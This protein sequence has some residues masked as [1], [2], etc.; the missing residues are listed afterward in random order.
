MPHYNYPT[1]HTRVTVHHSFLVTAV[2]KNKII[3]K[4]TDK[5]ASSFQLQKKMDIAYKTKPSNIEYS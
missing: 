3:S 4:A 5:N 1:K 2:S